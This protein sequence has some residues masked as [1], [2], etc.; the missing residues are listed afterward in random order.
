ML[1]LY[2]LI[3]FQD[4]WLHQAS[5]DFVILG[6]KRNVQRD[7]DCFPTTGTAETFLKQYPQVEALYIKF[8]TTHL[9]Q[10]NHSTL[11]RL[12]LYHFL[13][14]WMNHPTLLHHGSAI[15]Y[16]YGSTSYST[17]STAVPLSTAFM[18]RLISTTSTV[19]P[20][21]TASMPLPSSSESMALP[22][23]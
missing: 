10:I 23:Y 4:D 12:R 8:A 19:L 21:S 22:P 3:P 15:F 14:L 5:Y 20:V 6:H 9:L 13:L 16:C 17:T 2:L 18:E 1:S 7:T 11:L